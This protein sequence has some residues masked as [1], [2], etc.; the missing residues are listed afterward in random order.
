MKK[1]LLYLMTLL[2]FGAVPV[3]SF[4]TQYL[5]VPTEENGWD[6]EALEELPN[7]SVCTLTGVQI[8]AGKFALG[9]YDDTSDK[10]SWYKLGTSS[11]TLGESVSKGVVFA[12]TTTANSSHAQ[13]YALDGMADGTAGK[14]YDVTFNLRQYKVTVDPDNSHY[15]VY[16]QAAGTASNATQTSSLGVSG[17]TSFEVNT[18][19]NTYINLWLQASEGSDHEVFGNGSGITYSLTGGASAFEYTNSGAFT[20]NN[21]AAASRINGLKANTSYQ[22][23]VNFTERMLTVREVP[24]E[25]YFRG[26]YAQGGWDG[27]GIAA[28]RFQTVLEDDELVYVGHWKLTY[29]DGKGKYFCINVGPTKGSPDYQNQYGLQNIQDN[30]YYLQ[31]THLNQWLDL[32]K[33][34]VPYCSIYYDIQKS[35]DY[36]I[37]IKLDAN[38]KPAKIWFEEYTGSETGESTDYPNYYVTTH[39]GPYTHTTQNIYQEND[40]WIAKDNGQRSTTSEEEIIYDGLRLG[41]DNF[42]VET[43]SPDGDRLFW[44]LETAGTIIPGQDYPFKAMTLDQAMTTT[45]IDQSSQGLVNSRYDVIW[46]F[47]T[48]TCRV[49]LNEAWMSGDNQMYLYRLSDQEIADNVHKG[50]MLATI[51]AALQNESPDVFILE[52]SGDGIYEHDFFADEDNDLPRGTTFVLVGRTGQVYNIVTQTGDGFTFVDNN[53]DPVTNAMDFTLTN[54]DSQQPAFINTDAL[55]YG[56]FVVRVRT[57]FTGTLRGQNYTNAYIL[58]FTKQTQAPDHFVIYI[59]GDE[60]HGI[61]IPQEGTSKMYSLYPYDFDKTSDGGNQES[62]D[63]SGYYVSVQSGKWNWKNNYEAQPDANGYVLLNNVPIGN[64][65]FQI[66]IWDDNNDT[67]YAKGNINIDQATEINGN[68]SNM[69]VNGANAS[70]SFN[71]MFHVPTKTITVSKNTLSAPVGGGS[72]T[73]MYKFKA[74]YA[75]GTEV[76]Y[77]PSQYT[78]ASQQAY[79]ANS[80]TID[81]PLIS[82]HGEGGIKNE[83]RINPAEINIQW[84]NGSPMLM[85]TPAGVEKEVT[86]YFIDRAKWG[87]TMAVYAYSDL[88][89]HAVNGDWNGVEA[90]IKNGAFPG[91]D[92][93]VLGSTHTLYQTLGLNYNDTKI[94]TKTINMREYPDGGYSMPKVIFAKNDK[95]VQTKNLYMV[96]GGIYSNASTDGAN[97]A[98]EYLPRMQFTY[99]ATNPVDREVIEYDDTPYNVIYVD[100]PEFTQKVKYGGTVA[101]SIV[102]DRDGN[103]EMDYEALGIPGKHHAMLCEIAGVEMLRVPIAEYIVPDG[104]KVNLSFWEG[105]GAV[106]ENTDNDNHKDPKEK[107]YTNKYT[108]DKYTCTHSL[109]HGS[110]CSLNFTNVDYVDGYVYR[111][112]SENQEPII[113]IEELLRPK[114]V[115][116]VNDAANSAWLKTAMTKYEAVKAVD[117]QYTNG[118][119]NCYS[120]ELMDNNEASRMK[121]IIPEVTTAAKFHILAELQSGAWV[122][123]ST[124]A[125][126]TNGMTPNVPYTYQKDKTFAIGI[127]KEVYKNVDTYNIAI[128]FADNEVIATPNKVNAN[129][130][131]VTW[132]D[133]NELVTRY[134]SGLALP[135][136]ADEC[137]E[138]HLTEILFSYAPGYDNDA[139]TDPHNSKLAKL[140]VK[141]TPASETLQFFPT[142]TVNKLPEMIE[143]KVENVTDGQILCGKYV[144]ILQKS[145]LTDNKEGLASVMVKAYTA[146]KYDLSIAQTN[147]DEEWSR[148]DITVPIRV[149][150]TF[151]SVGL[152]INNYKLNQPVDFGGETGLLTPFNIDEV[153]KCYTINL[154]HEPHTDVNGNAEF[155]SRLHFQTQNAQ[156][157]IGGKQVM[158]IYW[159]ENPDCDPNTPNTTTPR[160][161]Q[162]RVI[163]VATVDNPKSVVEQPQFGTTNLLTDPTAEPF[164]SELTSPDGRAMTLTPYSIYNAPKV[165]IDSVNKTRKTSQQYVQLEQNG[166]KSPAY[167][168]VANRTADIPTE[169]EEIV[170]VEEGEAVYYNLNGFKVDADRL[171]PGIYVKVQGNRSEKIYVK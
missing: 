72:G 89:L 30:N 11:Q 93:T 120:L 10:I 6:I 63:Y 157:V 105:D 76:N 70:D 78:N 170:G 61:E 39:Y 62:C 36:L 168:L 92:M 2:V 42:C 27:Y 158:K 79:V 82:A 23:Y 59:D 14:L 43:L 32:V 107:E 127:N 24:I 137:D 108:G 155:K 129:F 128:T 135:A 118:I 31:G 21:N 125:L 9:V 141:F 109:C 58:T 106:T 47:T 144:K 115:Y 33:V 113:T 20:V 71:V 18:G 65:R 15:S 139:L 88:G 150:P 171:E 166:I 17:Q 51:E 102:Y 124:P 75:D 164:S 56:D 100:V 167:L 116:I 16:Y 117:P 96:D 103:G 85:V 35:E 73:G 48:K 25:L 94:W 154:S 121:Y 66:H 4:A 50:N 46:N 5:V 64:V 55:E 86:V 44:A 114:A 119:A 80:Q 110:H 74:V 111:R 169:V 156:D 123:Y 28:N 162:R 142:G 153:S 148:T 67:Y 95:T 38:N 1:L 133:N 152:T 99:F 104:V 57:N 52:R 45:K 134:K 130:Q 160:A 149:Y 122:E 34:T 161:P 101:V 138:D 29:E 60:E 140:T 112:Y 151:E 145:D 132:N 163:Q 81:I 84:N 49:E 131:F 87:G 147:T 54:S 3:D 53:F 26:D 68:E 37:K 40:M 7:G 146:G 98:T 83:Q 77:G 12:A 136:H 13:T 19:S 159:C 97:P 165:E 126:L 8:G 90:T 41:Y 143:R 91:Q 22:I 69:Y